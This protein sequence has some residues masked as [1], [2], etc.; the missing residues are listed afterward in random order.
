[1]TVTAFPAHR[2]E[3]IE[4]HCGWVRGTEPPS[5]RAWT[6]WLDWVEPDG[7]C[8]IVWTGSSYQA[9]RDAASYW[10]KSGVQ[11]VDKTGVY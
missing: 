1:M 3:R 9:A 11:I 10:S 2:S 5:P 4:V 7:S 6:Y 8:T